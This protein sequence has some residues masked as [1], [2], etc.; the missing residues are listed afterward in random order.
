M[1][2]VFALF[3]CIGL[4]VGCTPTPPPPPPP[5][6]PVTVTEPPATTGGELVIF[7][8]ED[9]LDPAVLDAFTRD[10]GINVIIAG[11]SDN[12]EMLIRL[13][14]AGGVGFDL[15]LCSDYVIAE[16]AL[17]GL[18]QPLDWDAIPNAVN[19]DPSFMNQYF[20][21]DAQYTVPFIFGTPLIV[22][23]PAR[24]DI[25]ITGYASLWDPALRESV[26][27][28]NDARLMMGFTMKSMGGSLNSR[29]PEIISAA[30]ERLAELWPNL[31][32]LDT[33]TSHHLMISGEA[34][35]GFMFTSHIKWTLAERPDLE[36]IFPEEGLGFGIDAFMLSSQAANVENAHIFLNYILQGPEAALLIEHSGFGGTNLAAVAYLPIHILEHRALYIPPEY[37]VGY[38]FIENLDP[39]TTELIFNAWERFLIAR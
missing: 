36:V 8:W 27:T 37:M 22:Y 13:S 15:I 21:P 29:D 31:V 17:Q 18:I 14:A 11:F 23:D 1:R 19:I 4:L 32:R 35:V 30:G 12:E 33:D 24:V 6:G 28:F 7:T 9:Y 34:T 5:P 16:S 25:P 26:V 2:K 3:L 38:E 10:T 20:D 39:A